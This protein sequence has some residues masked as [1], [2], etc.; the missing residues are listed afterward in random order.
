MK[1]TRFNADT[2]WRGKSYR[3]GGKRIQQMKI[4][5]L[6]LPDDWRSWYFAQHTDCGHAPTPPRSFHSNGT[7]TT[8]G[9][10]KLERGGV[11]LEDRLFGAG[12]LVCY[13]CA[14]R[15]L[16]AHMKMDGQ[17]LLHLKCTDG[18]HYKIVSEL[19][20]L[21]SAKVVLRKKW[22]SNMHDTRMSVRFDFNGE[23]WSGIGPGVGE[24]LRCRRTKYR[25]I[26]D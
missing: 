8:T 3:K 16:Q 20:Y 21:I 4:E 12:E 6:C 24:Y 10:V 18:V 26:W 15:I 1:R 9:L 13:D 19:G 11:R 7:P 22:R 5:Q 2:A 14:N 25:T 23:V 17:G